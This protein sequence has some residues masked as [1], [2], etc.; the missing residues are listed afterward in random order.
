MFKSMFMS[1]GMTP[2][3]DNTGKE[4]EVSDVALLDREESKVDPTAELND[5]FDD[6]LNIPPP[7]V[8]MEDIAID[9]IVIEGFQ[10]K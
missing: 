9:H 7:T 2:M 3:S 5:E 10:R 1:K 4:L 6:V 8:V